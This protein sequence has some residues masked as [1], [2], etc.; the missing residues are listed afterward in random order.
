M[1]Q[2]DKLQRRRR[3]IRQTK[4]KDNSVDGRRVRKVSTALFIVKRDS[5]CFGTLVDMRAQSTGH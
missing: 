5:L 2:K 4:L 1:A 3:S